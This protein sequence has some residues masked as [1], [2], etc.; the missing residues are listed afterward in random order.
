MRLQ[1]LLPLALCVERYVACMALPW[2]IRA[3]Q[4]TK[5]GCICCCVGLLLRVYLYLLPGTGPTAASYRALCV[6]GWGGG[7][8]RMNKSV[9]VC[10]VWVWVLRCLQ[11]VAWHVWQLILCIS[12]A[13]H[14]SHPGRWLLGLVAG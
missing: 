2:V 6:C 1:R 8:K 7:G 13:L 12:K 10:S 9:Y 11:L 5:Y 4:V 3:E 14:R